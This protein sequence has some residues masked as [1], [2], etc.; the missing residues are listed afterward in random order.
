MT[1]KNY[2]MIV[3]SFR[4]FRKYEKVFREKTIKSGSTKSEQL[5]LHCWID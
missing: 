3:G 2:L 5:S 4:I 1:K